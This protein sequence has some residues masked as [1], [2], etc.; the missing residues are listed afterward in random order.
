MARIG[1]Y[2]GA[3]QR[4]RMMQRQIAR[5]AFGCLLY[6]LTA[7]PAAAAEGIRFSENLPVAVAAAQKND[8]PV[9]VFYHAP[10]CPNCR[11][12]FRRTFTDSS[13]AQ[14]GK[15][16]EWV[17]VNIDRNAALVHTYGIEAIP[18]IQ[19]L[20]AS[21]Y[22]RATIVGRIGPAELNRRLAEIESRLARR[23]AASDATDVRR[24]EDGTA[25]EIV[26]SPDSFR[27]RNIC[28]ASVGYGPLNIPSQSPL[29][30]LRL[31]LAPAAPSTLAKG[32]KE[33]KARAT[34]VNI[35]ANEAD[36]FFDYEMLQTQVGLDY[37]LAETFQI[38][39]G[40]ETRSRFGGGMDSFIQEFHDLFDIDQNGR[41][42]VPRGD[43][44]FDIDPMDS[45]PG[46]SL[47][48]SDRGVF[49]SSAQL[50]FQHNIS[51][52]TEYWP[53]FAYTLVAQYEI[54]SD[55]LEGGNPWDF[56]LFLSA[57]QR[58]WDFYVYGGLGYTWFGREEFR[59][60]ELKDD[61]ISGNFAL[62]WRAFARAS[63]IAQYLYSQ[64]LAVDL[65]ELSDASHEINI[66]FKWECSPRVV[67]E[68]AL[69]ENFVTFANSPDFGVHGGVTLRFD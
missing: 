22:L 31:G 35:W 61:Q 1:D 36:Y 57:S 32:Q 54:E 39:I 40:F 29:Q 63:I 55:D 48:S 2:P 42:E 38:G 45:Q 66:G 56:A 53:A 21:G 69:I 50:K 5:A 9:A 58:F 51:C 28:Y 43:F 7:S 47:T 68:F 26:S 37:G 15:N 25:T 59:G 4:Q 65:G 24:Y 44:R 20:D 13:V 62:E 30:A 8:R 41:D 19:V 18:Q 64:G 60:I 16:F 67:L 34:W 49:S 11:E 3:I 52:G 27:A 33:V 6:L 46:V 14:A 17:A 12:M 23:P 10:W